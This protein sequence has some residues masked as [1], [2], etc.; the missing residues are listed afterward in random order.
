VVFFYDLI[1]CST[2][3]F[4]MAQINDLTWQELEA[5]SGISNIL[6]VDS[7]AGLLLRLSAL[8]GTITQDKNTSKVVQAIYRL[9]EYA[10]TAQAAVNVGQN[11]GER[12]SAFPPASSGGAINGYVITSGQ[13]IV[14]TPLATSGIIG[15]NN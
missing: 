8:T 14:A 5:A 9:R 7:T 1:G 2:N 15:A 12:L 4:F 10:A 6:I 3:I 11:I 13:I